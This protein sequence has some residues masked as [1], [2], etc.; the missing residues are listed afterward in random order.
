MMSILNRLRTG[1]ALI[2]L[3]LATGLALPASTAQAEYVGG[4]YLTNAR[5]CEVAGWPTMIEMFRARYDPSGAGR[6]STVVLDLAVGGTMIYNIRGDLDESRRWRRANG[7]AVWGGLYRSQPRPRVLVLER[8]SATTGNATVP[9][10]EQI[11]MSMRIMNFNGRR[12]CSV[13]AHM[14]LRDPQAPGVAY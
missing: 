14:M 13:D 6:I 1:P 10:H 11:R 3:T 8:M 5:G 9:G 4:G 12:G 2:V 7:Y